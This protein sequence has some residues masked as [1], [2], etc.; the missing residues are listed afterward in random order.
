MMKFAAAVADPQ[1]LHRQLDQLAGRADGRRLDLLTEQGVRFTQLLTERERVVALLRRA[2][3]D[4]SYRPGPA[5]LSR[6]FIAGKW[7]E[8][9]R[10]G[11]LDMI[12]HGVVAE[13]MGERL[14]S[15]LSP[16]VYSYRVKRSP[17]HALRWIAG[18]AKVHS[19]R[20][21]DP[22]TRGLYVL[23]SD[24]H[25]YAPSIPMGET[26][27]IW[28]ELRAV[29]DVDAESPHWTMI[30][31]LLL[32]DLLS[33]DGTPLSRET[34]VLFGAPTSNALMNLYLMPL[35]AALTPR[36]GAYARFGDDVL[37]AHEDPE[38]VRQAR[39][40]LEEVLA[41]RALKP[42]ESKL[43][44]LYWN[45][46]ARPSKEWPDAR[47]VATILFLGGGVGFDGT[48]SM[49][50]A[51]WKVM[52][53]DVR[54]RIRRTA[55]LMPD[56]SP[57]SRAKVLATVVNEAFDL[58]SDLGL[59]HKQMVSDLVSDRHQLAQLDYLLACWVAEA[60]TGALGPRAF[61]R[62]GYRW[63]RRTAGLESRV[64]FRNRRRH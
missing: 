31:A 47:P 29:C 40:V 11:P 60:S 63:L 52:L 44:V 54:A 39:V 42:N 49:S 10:L 17:W 33:E 56:A 6:S 18:I 48:I 37:F 43:H 13:V 12:V 25:S 20:R 8:I 59:G 38:V 4:G 22:R 57:E 61:R 5:Q 2:I 41:E 32:Q 21:P 19:A 28:P 58:R 35:D 53:H 15:H 30:R 45:G 1:R 62:L 64:V 23:R 34:G 51:K 14:E 50:P 46:A 55:R 27:R 24:V 26:S 16:R 36:G 9:A 3:A 7:R